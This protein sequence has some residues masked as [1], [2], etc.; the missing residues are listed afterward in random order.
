M[1]DIDGKA[2]SISRLAVALP[3]YKKTIAYL[4][5]GSFV[6]GFVL[7]LLM[8]RNS[9]SNAM[10]SD[11]LVFGGAE[12]VFFLGVP[13]LLAGVI[14]TG[15]ARK[16][17]FG[18]RLKHFTFVS[19]L[20]AIA[21]FLFYFAGAVLYRRFADLATYALLANSAVFL[22]WFLAL[23]VGL[24]YG[25]KSLVMASFHPVLNLSFLTIWSSFLIAGLNDP[26]IILVKFAASSAVL[27]LGMVSL[28]YIL[29][30]PAKRNFGASTLQVATLFFAQTVYGKKDIEDFFAEISETTHTTLGGVAF[31]RRNGE[32]KAVF[33]VPN[34]HYGPFGNV[35][36]SEF[37]STI[38]NAV[39]AELRCPALVFHGTAGHD[40]N[41]V[42]SFSS[43]RLA[44]EY[45]QT[46]RAARSY[47]A[48]ASF[49]RQENKNA[50][51][52]GL[53]FGRRHSSFVAMTRAPQ[54]TDDIDLPLGMALSGALHASGFGESVL[55]DMHNS[56][57]EE[58][59][60]GSGSPQFFEFYDLL[61]SVSNVKPPKAFKVGV[62]VD[63]LIGFNAS[64]GIGTA[65]LKAVVFEIGAKRACLILV[66]AN[67]VMPAFRRAVLLK[68]LSK[69]NFTYCDVLTTD[70]HS[71][72][73]ISG[74]HNPLGAHKDNDKLIPL[75]EAAV[76]LAVADLEPA[77]AAVVNRRTTLEVLGSGRTPEL[78]STI[79]AIVSM[80]KIFAPVILFLSVVVA[81]LLLITMG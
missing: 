18:P 68:V 65:G 71:V 35:G 72:N 46:I 57:C 41:P 8:A 28:F 12:G 69:F 67:N 37:P 59:K 47:D 19:L 53:S 30:A 3:S 61:S 48:T 62:A 16:E 54:N 70:T 10:L 52:F 24:N 2:T 34:V 6:S 81:A 1:D 15:V 42:Y 56:K 55:V 22:I 27:L 7:R 75:I 76:A 50:K 14:A 13:A 40:L 73:N 58:Q 49:L 44:S 66:D 80:A 63:P 33:L 11:S 78:L 9:F 64:H 4:F 20:A 77:S 17:G 74:V 60:M 39:G 23:F 51:V 43:S 26:F 38:A 25:W 31:K 29:N 5:A 45:V 21:S 79:S 32:Y 36:G